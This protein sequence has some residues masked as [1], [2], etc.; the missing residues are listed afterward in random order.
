MSRFFGH[1]APYL[2]GRA[3]NLTVL[4]RQ[5]D[6]RLIRNDLLQLLLTAPGERVMRP[7]WG[8][9]IRTFVFGQ[10]SDRDQERLKRDI[11]RA[12]D[13][14][15]RRVRVTDIQ[16]EFNDNNQA[17]IKI[18]GH[19][20]LDRFGLTEDIGPLAQADLLVEL[21]LDTSR[22]NEQR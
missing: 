5:E 18:Y 21:N 19:F 7:D 20:S 17:L 10:M 22:F 13:R 1:N 8:S 3:G 4:P 2:Q 15:E 6:D 14:H 9:P 16:V 11:K 12:I